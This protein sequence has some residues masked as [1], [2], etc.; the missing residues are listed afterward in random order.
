MPTLHIVST[1]EFTFRGA[2]E[3]WSNGY[4]FQTGTNTVDAAFVQSVYE[5]VRDA[6]KSFHANNVR[7]V[8]G[9]GGLLNEDAIWSNEYGGAGPLGAQVAVQ[10]HQETAVMAES[11]LRNKVY[12]RKFFHTCRH[13][14]GAGDT[15]DQMSGPDKTAINTALAKLTDGTMP[16]G[17]KACFPD[18]ALA[19]APFTCDPFL[20]TRQL[21]RRGRRPTP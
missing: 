2:P 6:E 12:L 1:K 3:R 17:V 4:N 21:K 19:I 5:A 7:F 8:Y 11:K 9:V 13:L 15:A 14:G 10:M 18:G 20:R 16:G